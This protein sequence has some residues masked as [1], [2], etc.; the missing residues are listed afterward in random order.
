VTACHDLLAL[1]LAGI[2]DTALFTPSWSGW[3]ADPDRP[4]ALGDEP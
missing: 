4:A 3:S 1:R 2:T